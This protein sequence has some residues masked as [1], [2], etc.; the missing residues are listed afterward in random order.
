MVKFV[1]CLSHH[2]NGRFVEETYRRTWFKNNSTWWKCLDCNAVMEKT[3]VEL[4]RD[5][6]WQLIEEGVDDPN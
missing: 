3:G 1:W 5:S 2:G 6:D 4:N